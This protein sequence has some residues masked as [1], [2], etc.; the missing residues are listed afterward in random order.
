MNYW[1]VA[2]VVLA[3][4]LIAVATVVAFFFRLLR[5]RDRRISELEQRTGA[6]KRLCTALVAETEHLVSGRLPAVLDARARRYPGVVV[7]GLRE[8]MLDGKPIAAAHTKILDIVGEATEITQESIGRAARAG[9]RGLCSAVQTGLIKQQMLIEKELH[10]HQ[11]APEYHQSLMG[12]DQ[13]TTRALHEVQRLLILSGSWPGVQRANSSFGAIVESARGRADDY[14]RVDYAYRRDTGEVYVEGRVVEPVILALTELLDNALNCT[15][16]RVDVYVRDV[17]GGYTVVVED[18][19]RGMNAFQRA[20]AAKILRHSE[21]MDVTTLTDERRL[22]FPVVGW[23]ANEYG[24]GVDV[25]APSAS[26]GVKA[27]TFVPLSLL[28]EAPTEPEL[29][30]DEGVASGSAAVGESP[31]NGAAASTASGL[32]RRTRRRH[33]RVSSTN[34]ATASQEPITEGTDSAA[35]AAGMESISEA[36]P[37]FSDDNEST[38]QGPEHG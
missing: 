38:T 19:G 12:I 16:G 36:L 18:S 37:D 5:S 1:H 9:V 13:L 29:R 26:G 7:P 2:A 15:A 23:L 25:D 33:A 11:A 4:G 28:G 20:E 27:V 3:V 35:F 31:R 34:T 24:F 14:R 17:Q 30:L 22:G 6:A 10:N 32:P 21:V 8:P